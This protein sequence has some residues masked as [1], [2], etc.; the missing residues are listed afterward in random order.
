MSLI[1]AFIQVYNLV[2]QSEVY[3]ICLYMQDELYRPVMNPKM[4]HLELNILL[5]V[6]LT[7]IEL[8]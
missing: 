6:Q 3:I 2:L 7:L 4:F 8:L 5:E 1:H